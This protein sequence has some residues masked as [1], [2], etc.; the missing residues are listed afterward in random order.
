MRKDTFS[1]FPK[2]TLKQQ[3]YQLDTSQL[4]PTLVTSHITQRMSHNKKRKGTA[5]AANTVSLSK[6][7]FLMQ[8]EG[9]LRVLRL[10]RKT[11]I[12]RKHKIMS[13][14]SSCGN[15]KWLGYLKK[16]CEHFKRKFAEGP[17]NGIRRLLNNRFK[18]IDS[19]RDSLKN[20]LIGNKILRIFYIYIII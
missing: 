19:V 14:A 1:C 3:G 15:E 11:N 18:E 2:D 17:T 5:A 13:K 12:S 8:D 6:S 7:T 20:A 4:Y 9:L 16:R 10:L